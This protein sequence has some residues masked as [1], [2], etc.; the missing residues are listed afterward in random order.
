MGS[1]F[2][3]LFVCLFINLFVCLLVCLFVSLFVCLFVGLFVCLVGVSWYFYFLKKTFFLLYD[4]FDIGTFTISNGGVYGSMMGTPIINPPQTAILGM[5][6][7]TNRVSKK[8]K[9]KSR[10]PPMSHL[11]FFFSHISFI[12]LFLIII[13]IGCCGWQ[14][15]SK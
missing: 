2:V 6:G 14:G 8:K 1:Q 11:F 9:K 3:G 12:L 7:I 15:D 10:C 13:L 5:H 4:I